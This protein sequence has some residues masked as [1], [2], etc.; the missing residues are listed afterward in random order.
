MNRALPIAVLSVLFVVSTAF[1]VY[2]V[3]M[4]PLTPEHV[5]QKGFLVRIATEIQKTWPNTDARDVN[6]LKEHLSSLAAENEWLTVSWSTMNGGG[7]GTLML[8]SSQ[9]AT[10]SE[11][12]VVQ[13]NGPEGLSVTRHGLQGVDAHEV[14]ADIGRGELSVLGYAKHK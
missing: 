7:Q 13:A 8:V 10:L 9:G 3:F 14:K 4:R 5:R 12:L 11:V 1:I 6:E 2:V